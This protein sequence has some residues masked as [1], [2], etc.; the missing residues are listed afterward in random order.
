MKMLLWVRAPQAEQATA[1]APERKPEQIK[2]I[3][4][5]KR[6]QDFLLYVLATPLGAVQQPFYV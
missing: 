2:R 4:S 6:Q 3:S 1:V 5:Q